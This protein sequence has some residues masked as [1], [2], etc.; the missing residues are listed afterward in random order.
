[1]A[2]AQQGKEP[3]KLCFVTIGA[4]AAFDGLVRAVF[5]SSV[6]SALQAGGYSK[7]LVQYGKDGKAL[8]ETLSQREQQKIYGVNFEGF[9]FDTD[10]LTQY[11]VEARRSGGCVV[12]HGGKPSDY[13]PGPALL[14][15]L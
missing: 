7:L 2:M 8:F 10:G 15:K 9:D 1:M 12:S 4:T 5:D 13:S 11:M 3:Q 6:L 14:R